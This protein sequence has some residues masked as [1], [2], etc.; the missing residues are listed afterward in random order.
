MNIPSNL[1]NRISE[2]LK[3][4]LARNTLDPK[5]FQTVPSSN[6]FN[7]KIYQSVPDRV[8]GF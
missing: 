7:P 1:K 8:I 2:L 4:T 6:E 3:K 5:N